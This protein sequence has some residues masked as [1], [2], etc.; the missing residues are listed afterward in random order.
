M[1]TI[2]DGTYVIG[3]TSATNFVAG[4]GISITEPSEGTVRIANDETVLWSGTGNISTFTLSEKL[5]N[6]ERFRMVFQ[7]YNTNQRG[8]C[9]YYSPADGSNISYM[10]QHYVAGTD[11]NPLQLWAGRFSSNDNLTYNLVD[12]KWMCMPGNSNAWTNTWNDNDRKPLINRII[13]INRI[14]GGNE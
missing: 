11:G 5:S 4:P 2:Y 3:Q 12:W 13:G 10:Y 6:F 8:S 14:S 1:N 7:G 9:E